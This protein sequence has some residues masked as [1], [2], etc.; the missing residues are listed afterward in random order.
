MGV[1]YITGGASAGK[2]Y[3]VLDQI[4]K[5]LQKKDDH[6]L[7]LLVPE[8]FTLQAERDLIEKQ[9]LKGI[10]QAEVLSFTRLAYKVFNEVGGLKRI[11]INDIGKSM[12]LKKILEEYGNELSI[13]KKTCKQEGFVSRLNEMICEFKQHDISPMDLNQ[14]VEEIEEDSILKMKLQDITLLYEKFNKY[15]ENRYVDNEDHLNLLIEY[16]EKAQFLEE[17]EIWIDG[18]HTF[19]PQTLRIIEKLMTKVRHMYITFSIDLQGKDADKDLFQVSQR[20]YLKIKAMVNKLDIQEDTVYLDGEKREGIKKAKEI[21]HIEGELY[22]YPYKKYKSEV[23]N[24]KIF[25]GSNPYSEV[26]HTAAEI[27]TLVRDRGYRFRDIAVVSG[28]FE[29]YSSIVKRV[30]EEYGIPYFMDEKRSIMNNPIVEFILAAIETVLKN[31]QYKDMFRLIKTGFSDLSKDEVEILENYVLQ[32]GI[33]GYRWRED[34][35]LGKK[36]E[37]L[38][39]NDIREK[40]MNPLLTLEKRIIKSK[41]PK[42]ITKSVFQFLQ[43]MRIEEKLEIWIE[44]LK[45]AGRFDYVNENAQIWNSVMEIFDQISE[46]LEENKVSLRDYYKILES[47]FSACEIG[48]IPSTIDQVLVGNMARSRSHDIKALLVMG[49]NDGIL[50]A[51]HDDEGILLEHE[52]K[53]LENEGLE[54]AISGEGKLLQQQFSIYSAFAKPQE[55]LWISYALGDEEGRAKRPSTLID[56][57]KKLFPQLE[58]KSD[59]LSNS[60]QQLSLVSTAN[61][62]FKHLVENIRFYLDHESMEELWW[63]VYYWY[64]S[65]PNWHEK[66]DLV[67]EGLF[68]E[69]QIQYIDETKAQHLYNLPIKTSVSRLESF[70]NCPFS[71]FVTYGLKPKERKEYQLK[72]PDIGKLFHYSMDRFAQKTQEE[73]ISWVDMEREQCDGL[74]EDV[75]EQLAEEFESGVMLSTHRY[76]YLVTRLKR[77]SKKALWTLIEHI[78]SGEFTPYG[79]E[80]PFGIDHEIPGIVIELENGE[81]VILEGR[82][83]RV[84]I[85]EDEDGIYLKVIDYKSGNKEFNLS[86]V[87]YGF[88]LQLIVYLEAMMALEGKVKRSKNHPAGAFYFKIDDPMIRTTEK[89]VEVI[90]K[91][92]NKK[93]KMKGLVLKDLKV[94]KSIDKN[95]ER[96]SNI[97]PVS[98][99]KDESLSKKSSVASEEDF[100]HLINH[101]KGLIKEIAK[102]IVKG[103]IKIEPYKKKKQT[104]CEYCSYKA[105][106]QFDAVFEENKYRNIKE[107]KDEEVLDKIK[108]RGEE[109]LGD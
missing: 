5:R 41:N 40:L 73:N 58:I 11:P 35:T 15:L 1:T 98:I 6:N 63:D 38:K 87:Y 37:L 3:Y 79:H 93:L 51:I 74:V 42:K 85:L 92:V 22:R 107:L 88:Q 68:H 16:I 84:D 109:V 52:K 89:A 75:L 9:Q 4:K 13:Y 27:I 80:V 96:D 28:N 105:I 45:L 62:T 97:I 23:N 60:Q 34:F 95:I 26:E 47:G 103:N 54:L 50:P 91:E 36:E 76:K 82:I 67:I 78:K 102:E 18:F 8:Q 30:F 106:C 29:G 44:D 94:I 101:V 69:N 39:I 12:I 108:R 31:Y 83:D 104:S 66:K 72:S 10:M 49:V 46:I 99:N 43:D 20:T 70:V 100:L 48:V 24:L 64:N 17:A 65:H 56:M 81:E 57:L 33:R 7:I 19:T 59:I 53:T 71:H 86:E 55:Y 25:S 77:I 61:S 2:T 90:E 14:K 21:S 32:Y